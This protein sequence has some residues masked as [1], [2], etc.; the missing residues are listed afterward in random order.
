M[1]FISTGKHIHIRAPD[2][3]GTNYFNYKKTFSIVLMAVADADYKFTMID[4]GQMGS[5][6]DGGV[7]DHSTMGSG[8]NLG[9]FLIR[10][11]WVTMQLLM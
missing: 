5:V 10:M 1:F 7:W 11:I 9:M 2:N 3:S 4:V 6:S 8:W